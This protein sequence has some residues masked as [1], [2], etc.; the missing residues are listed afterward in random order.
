MT[1]LPAFKTCT[2]IGAAFMAAP[3]LGPAS[4]VSADDTH[5][6]HGISLDC[7]PA[8]LP[9][10]HS[11][12]CSVK[13]SNEGRRLFAEETFG[14]NG[15][16]CETCHSAETGTF[17]P[18]DA[19]ARLLADPNDPLF[20]HDGL[21]DGFTGI[22]R[23]IAHA[24]VRI[25][26]PLPPNVTL[27]HEP[28]ATHITVNRGTP[29]VLNTPA[30]EEVFM[31]D[32]RDGTLQQQ[33]LGAIE[34]H[35]QNTI[36]P[37]ALELDLIAEFQQT[38]PRFFSNGKLRKFAGGG[39]PPELPLG[40]TESEQRGRLFFIDAPFDPPSKVGVCALCHSGPMLNEANVFS[41]PVFGNPPG[42]RAHNVQVA[43]RNLLGN[44]LM[45]FIV[46]DTVD[47]DNPVEVTTPDPGKLLT[48][49]AHLIAIGEIPPDPVLALLGLRRAF[50][51][52]FFKIPTLWGVKHTAPYFHDNSAKDLD[53]MLDQYDFFF[54]NTPFRI[55][56]QVQLTEQDKED[57]K[58]FL[59][60]L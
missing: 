7:D 24:T 10:P 12:L 36:A 37:T 48:D 44:P 42:V 3:A 17:S 26:L 23:I 20:L 56:G 21:D 27:K 14:G 31:Y 30:L 1:R 15:R 9:E 29:T 57:I 33:A 35:A 53:E 43:E 32:V 34:S 51:A 2:L 28:E 4:T 8:A 55:R 46:A 13:R 45:T 52:N 41:P 6:V 5:P 50:F 59:Q 38:A 40:T 60:L 19:L 22:S 16:T 49:N 11:T 18:E 25:T 54:E 39:P 47:P 58:A